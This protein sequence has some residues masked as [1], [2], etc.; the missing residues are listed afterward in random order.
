[1]II[2]G[3][4][5]NY[6]EGNRKNSIYTSYTIYNI[7]KRKLNSIN[8][9]QS[10]ICTCSNVVRRRKQTKCNFETVF[11]PENYRFKVKSSK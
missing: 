1:M 8:E 4:G 6:L 11:Y 3:S 7:G 2:S 10:M 5:E 9:F